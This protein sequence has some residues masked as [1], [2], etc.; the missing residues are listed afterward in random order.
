MSIIFDPTNTKSIKKIIKTY[1]KSGLLS[2]GEA[3]N[4]DSVTL[5]VC[6]DHITTETLQRN[7]WTRINTYW[8]D[9][10]AEESYKR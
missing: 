2:M 6:A 5:S 1:G 3:A 9:G 10:T 8:A 7:G 4:G